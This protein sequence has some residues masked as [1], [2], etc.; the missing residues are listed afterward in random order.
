VFLH[1]VTEE[2]I[3]A[4]ALA[5]SEARLRLFIDRAPAAIA[6]FDTE[7]RYLAASRRFARDYHL[8]DSLPETLIGRSHYELFPEM[9]QR[10]RDIHRR[11]LAGETLSAEEDPFPRESGRTD[12][13][14][15]EMAPWRR[16]N[17]EIGGAVLFSE[18]INERKEAE[19][20][21]RGV[22]D[23]LTARLRENENLTARLRAEVEAR[24]TAQTRATH[25]ER[26]QALGQFAGGMAHD[27]N[28]LLG[29]I[30][31][32]LGVA[33][34]MLSDSDR[35]RKLVVDA[36][37]AARSGAELI[38]GLLAF[39]RHQPLRPIRIEINEQV[40]GM[41]RLLSRVLGDHIEIT[42]RCAPDLWSVI[43]DPSQVEACLMN[44]AANARDAMPQGGRLTI[45][46]AN[47]PLD[48]DY[49]KLNPSVTPGDYAMIAVSDT[50]TGMTPEVLAKVFEPFFTTK[51]VGK[52]TGLGLS[53]VFGFASQSGG[54]VSIYSE[55]GV[56]TTIRLFLPRA[57]NTVEPDVPVGAPVPA[58][59][60]AGHGETVLVVEDNA[61]M[62][63]AVVQQLALLNYRVL[64]TD[65]APAALSVLETEKVDLVFSDVIMPGGM[66]GVELAECARTRWSSV[67][68]LLTSGFLGSQA[69]KQ[70]EGPTAPP[71]L[72]Y[73]PYELAQL[74]QA[75]RGTLDA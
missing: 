69:S 72:L 43:A 35:L 5:E 66:N 17:G 29:V 31:M 25:A 57:Q 67:K 3:T 13:V 16:A 70:F 74:A 39:A 46:T 1:D 8:G 56:G 48:A 53:M 51:E 6:M 34:R 45:T 71:R 42:L 60:E 38:R 4:T 22:T 41:L 33:Q 68:V 23:D 28:N 10:W 50:G 65:S 61:A 20:A 18:I 26:V 9:P 52:G 27:F 14:H 36:L 11:V 12:W 75:V 2:R 24:E 40:S 15:W 32:N 44:L 47:Q 64:E 37:A 30:I 58:V 21:L 49:A 54:H 62:R 63:H 19:V 59:D 73:K 55:P 7:M